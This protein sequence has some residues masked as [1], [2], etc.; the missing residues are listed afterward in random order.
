MVR[1]FEKEILDEIGFVSIYLNAKNRFIGDKNPSFNITK[2]EVKQFL[3]KIPNY[4]F[5]NYSNDYYSDVIK[6]GWTFRLFFDIKYGTVITYIYVLYENKFVSNGLSNLGRILD[7]I[8][9]QGYEIN[10]QFGLN[11]QEEMLEY[12]LIMIRIYEA[13]VE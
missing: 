4:K 9:L 2:P 12:L 3:K 10:N 11:S 7:N 8:D 6:D 13:F 1:K 5:K